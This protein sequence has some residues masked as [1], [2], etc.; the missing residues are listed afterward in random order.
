MSRKTE[1][2]RK[3]GAVMEK[4]EHARVRV[5]K[6]ATSKAQVVQPEPPNPGQ[7]PLTAKGIAFQ[8]TGGYC[9]CGCGGALNKGR[10]FVQGHDARVKGWL[11]K[12]GRGEM[13]ATTLP[14]RVQALLSEYTKCPCCGQ[15][16]LLGKSECD[17]SRC[18]CHL[19]REIE[20]KNGK[21]NNHA[22][23]VVSDAEIERGQDE[24]EVDEDEDTL[25][26]EDTLHAQAE[27]F[28]LSE[29]N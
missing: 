28:A 8:R 4:K 20:K 21:A 10:Y 15:P 5:K 12:V 11:I 17:H 29:A 18:N 24:A 14:A 27:A 1:R 6:D 16:V 13:D 22:H 7:A 9:L 19:R 26:D 25:S 3:G 2:E 23:N